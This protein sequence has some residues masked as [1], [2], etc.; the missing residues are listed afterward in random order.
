MQTRPFVVWNGKKNAFYSNKKKII[1][2][3]QSPGDEE[4]PI[5]WDGAWQEF[6]GQKTEA[7]TEKRR[8]NFKRAS[9]APK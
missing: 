1:P 6:A 4:K 5:D 8:D 3:S 2:S 9:E 7:S